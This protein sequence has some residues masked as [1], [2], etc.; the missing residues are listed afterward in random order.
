VR[1]SVGQVGIRTTGADQPISGLSGGN[2]QKVLLARALLTSPDVLLLD[3]PTRG[4]D[5][6]AKE[7]VY[8][9]IRSIAAAGTTVLIASM[10]EP[11]I[12]AL[13]DRI[14]VLR[15][16]KQ[17]ALLDRENADEDSLTILA[18]GGVV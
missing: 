17:S 4:I 12:L 16:G 15:N 7:D 1:E 5:I 18:A 3:E 10:E 8:E 14:L 2:Q 9:W 13:A 11:E 6:G